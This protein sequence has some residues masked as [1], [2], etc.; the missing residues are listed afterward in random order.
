MKLHILSANAQLY[1]TRRLVEEA[2]RAA[3]RVEII[4]YRQSPLNNKAISTPPAAVIP[5]VAANMSE[6]GLAWIEAYEAIG[7]TSVI[8]AEALRIVRNKP[9]CLA[10]LQAANLPT[11]KSQIITPKLELVNLLKE[12]FRFPLILKL[13]E[14]THG[15]GVLLVRTAAGLRRMMKLF[16]AHQPFLIQEFVKEAA[17]TDI[18]AFVVDNKVVASMKRTAKGDDF[19]SN[20]H[21]GGTA[22]SIELRESEQLMAVKACQELG[23]AVAGVDMLFSS[24]GLMIIEVNASPGLEGIEKV[25]GQ[26]I[27]Q[28]IV[29]Y[30]LAK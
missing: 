26:N 29:K 12:G 3:C 11:P 6:E 21:R 20:L 9:A 19:R 30:S 10:R 13:A 24:K 25:S 8:S 27:A 23:I 1:S 4:D 28:Q 2:K 22:K 16:K 18:R 7:V 15:H 5:R 17:G 14:S